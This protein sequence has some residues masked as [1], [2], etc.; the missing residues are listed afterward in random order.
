MKKIWSTRG[1]PFPHTTA[2]VASGETPQSEAQEVL[3]FNPLVPLIEDKLM[4][5]TTNPESR[6]P[7]GQPKIDEFFAQQ[8]WLL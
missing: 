4:K 1:G 3:L 5:K 6:S 7:P 2:E 8:Q